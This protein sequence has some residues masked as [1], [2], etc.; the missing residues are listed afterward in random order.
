MLL[1]MLEKISL[2]GKG[3]NR[4]YNILQI[5]SD[6]VLLNVQDRWENILNEEISVTEISRGF[7]NTQ[8]IPK[9]EYNRCVQFKILHD[10]LNTRQLLCK[11]KY[12]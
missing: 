10:R 5:I 2:G 12:I 6:S 4:I 7:Y 9:S 3:C 11:M 1:V 8:K